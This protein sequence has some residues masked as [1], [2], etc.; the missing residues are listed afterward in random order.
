MSPSDMNLNDRHISIAA[1][2]NHNGARLFLFDR[3]IDLGNEL[4]ADRRQGELDECLSQGMRL[5]LRQEKDG[6][7]EQI[8]AVFDG[9]AFRFDFVERQEF[10]RNTA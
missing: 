1:S 4:L 3:N 6:P 10:D 7:A 5:L 8:A 9:R 2:F